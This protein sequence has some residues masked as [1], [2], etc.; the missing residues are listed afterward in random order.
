MNLFLIGYRGTGKS[1]IG[2]LLAERLG[3][4][5]VDADPYLEIKAGKTIKEIFATQGEPAFRD[6]E[7][8]VVAELGAGDSQVLALGGGAVMR[9]ETRLIISTC[10]KALWL[11]ASPETIFQRISGDPTTTQR[12]PDLTAY[13]GYNE[14]VELLKRREPIY[15][16][17]ADYS[18]D[19]EG[20][21]VDQIVTE[22]LCLVGRG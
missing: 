14:I 9:D 8:S 4:K 5:F 16:Q 20:K 22:I 15:H 19:T 3:W 18:V 21:S 12:R 2:R 17:C 7:A 10:G 6:I 11:Q 13:G 1:T